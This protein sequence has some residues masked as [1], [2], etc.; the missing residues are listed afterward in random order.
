MKSVVEY[1]ICATSH[2]ISELNSFNNEMHA[3]MWTCSSF[4]SCFALCFFVNV[5]WI[6]PEK[7]EFET[8]TQNH[9]TFTYVLKY[10]PPLLRVSQI[11]L[12]I[13]ALGSGGSVFSKMD[14]PMTD[15]SKSFGV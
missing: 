7:R 1:T 10:P 13:D 9:V 6:R 14:S 12:I 11:R 3:G 15:Y 2:P 5:C 8:F 4:L